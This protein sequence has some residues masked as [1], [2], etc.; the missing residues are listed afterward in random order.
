M[1]Q[2]EPR[3]PSKADAMRQ[4]R[5]ATA[6]KKRKQRQLILSAA[7]VLIV[8]I[9]VA[10]ACVLFVFLRRDDKNAPAPDD[11]QQTT[12]SVSDDAQTTSPTQTTKMTES[13]A[14]SQTTA[15]TPATDTTSTTAASQT[16]GD[17]LQS[18]IFTYTAGGQITGSPTSYSNLVLNINGDTVG[19]DAYRLSYENYV[20]RW[21]E[22][23][24]GRAVRDYSTDEGGG[25]SWFHLVFAGTDHDTRLGLRVN[26][27]RVSYGAEV[28]MPDRTDAVAF[29]LNGITLGARSDQVVSTFGTPT[30]QT[31]TELS[32]AF[33]N[34]G[35]LSF[36]LTDGAVSQIRL[37]W[38]AFTE[39]N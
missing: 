39:T 25:E 18:P 26:G 32:Y 36:R 6:R 2:Q 24:R 37:T 16:P 13:T 10:A 15:S 12:A 7:A 4:K 11:T 35:L 1:N 22:A 30:S 8:L 33:E 21:Y 14:S 9:L 3:R 17:T 23:L 34:G 29:S 20:P 27:S 5:L 31:Q 28:G 19:A 38:I